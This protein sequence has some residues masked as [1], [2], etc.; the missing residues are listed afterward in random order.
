MNLLANVLFVLG[1][2]ALAVFAPSSN[3]VIALAAAVI[4]VILII[5]S[6]AI[7]VFR[8]AEQSEGGSQRSR[9]LRYWP[10]LA[11]PLGGILLALCFPPFDHTGLI[12]AF[13]RLLHSSAYI[14]L[15]RRRLWAQPTSHRIISWTNC[16]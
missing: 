5:A 1:L 2:A 16:R 3:R 15:W 8:L 9:V 11:A 7:A 13:L 12:W 10:Y 4:G 6:V 14:Y